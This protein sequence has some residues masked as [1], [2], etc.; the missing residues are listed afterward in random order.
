M[1][2]HHDRIEG[3]KAI[4]AYLGRE[5]STVIRWYKERGLPVHAM[6]GGKTRRVYALKPEL[7]AWRTALPPIEPDADAA[8]APGPSA[9]PV[10]P[11]FGLPPQAQGR[12]WLLASACVAIVA[13]LALGLA[14]ALSRAPDRTQALP[15]DP[16][17]AQ[18]FITAR[19]DLARRD[20]L[21]LEEA[22]TQLQAITRTEPDFALGQASLADAYI[23]GREFGSIDDAEAFP[24]IDRAARRALALDPDLASAHRAA[25]FVD[26]W[27]RGDGR[28][29][30]SGFRRALA[31]DDRDGF[32]HLWFAN[33][34]ADNGDAAAAVREFAAAKRYQPGAPSIRIDEAWAIWSAGDDT[35]ATHLLTQVAQQQPTLAAT[36]D[37]L[38]FIALG[39][40][41]L[42]G[43][44]RE[45]QQRARF[46]NEA[47]LSAYAQAVARSVAARDIDGLALLMMERARTAD[48]GNRPDLSL[49]AFFESALGRRSAL[50][51]L[52]RQAESRRES[53]QGA[54]LRLHIARRWRDDREVLD[55]L[56]RRAPPPLT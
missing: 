39:R 34:L 28:A 26:Y 1:A 12:R 31:L 6:P 18:R 20:A 24:K 36:Y 55:L 53:W 16:A 40:G 50:L 47:A 33:I 54:G 29:A 9:A 52:L 56:R 42:A 15:R 11:D 3:W 7:D 23:L 4:G 17:L 21:S 49:E 22:T 46:K 48:S 5:R 25:A 44:S 8:L 30:A 32:T 43:Y 19:D 27:W 41:D 10:L 37:C 45:L 13:A 35:R 38:S 2:T 14:F 51:T